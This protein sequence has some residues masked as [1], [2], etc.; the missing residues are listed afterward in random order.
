MLLH[1]WPLLHLRPVITF[2]PSTG[3]LTCTTS[4]TSL[5]QCQ[6]PPTIWSLAKFKATKSHSI[7]RATGNR[8]RMQSRSLQKVRDKANSKSSQVTR[9][10][11]RNLNAFRVKK[12]HWLSQWD[13]FKKLSLYHHHQFV[14]SKHLCINCLVPGH[15]VQDCPN[16]R[17]CRAERCT[18]KHSTFLYEK[19]SL[20]K[21]SSINKEYQPSNQGQV[22]SPST[23]QAKNG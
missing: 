22:T 16:R 10:K 11:E 2:M 15:F 23:T 8:K 19:Q 13:E 6:E 20:P 4:Q 18:K 9:K 7:K 21:P 3:I 12:D 5:K 17:F 1:L 14:W